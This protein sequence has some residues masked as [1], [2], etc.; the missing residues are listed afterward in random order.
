MSRV[1]LADATYK[2][3]IL[4][5]LTTCG[6][7]HLHRDPRHV[8][9]FSTE[10]STTFG[11][12]QASRRASSTA[13]RARLSSV[14]MKNALIAETALTQG[15]GTAPKCTVRMRPLSNVNTAMNF[16]AAHVD[17]RSVFIISH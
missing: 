10:C 14:A 8:D 13:S 17:V 2:A 5:K 11:G 16:L 4:A 9:A 3:A 6:F 1:V 7:T 12:R 15:V